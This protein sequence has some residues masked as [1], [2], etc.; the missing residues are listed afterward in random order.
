MEV[1]K[2]LREQR[3]SGLITYSPFAAVKDSHLAKEKQ[4]FS[5]ALPLMDTK[6]Y[7]A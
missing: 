4:R 1:L 6:P 3:K 5:R 7:P 2:M